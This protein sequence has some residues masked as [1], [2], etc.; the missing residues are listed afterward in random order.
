MEVATKA[1]LT[2]PECSF[3]QGVDMPT[4]VCQFFYECVNCGSV[5][6]PKSSDCC[7]F[8]SYADTRCPPEQLGKKE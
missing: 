6:K 3:A 5:L 4:D 7:I 8:C 1:K 2:C